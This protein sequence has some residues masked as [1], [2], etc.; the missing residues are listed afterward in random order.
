M[1]LRAD[2]DDVLELNSG[3]SRCIWIR[4]ISDT[5]S[6]CTKGFPPDERCWT[7]EDNPCWAFM[8]PIGELKED[9]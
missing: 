5:E 6:V 3:E 4:D 7:G 9:R 8:R 1:I 2:N